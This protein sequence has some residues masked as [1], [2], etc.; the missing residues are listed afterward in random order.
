MV[1][2][3][4]RYGIP[5]M[6]AGYSQGAE[7]SYYSAMTYQAN[8]VAVN[9]GCPKYWIGWWGGVNYAYGAE[10]KGK[11]RNIPTDIQQGKWD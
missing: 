11:G 10:L 5:V 2:G 7:I 1:Y 3:F 8:A 9:A 4:H 6:L